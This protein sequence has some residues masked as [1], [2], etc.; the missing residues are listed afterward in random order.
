MVDVCDRPGL[1]ERMP[2]IEKSKSTD[3]ITNGV[4]NVDMDDDLV[5]TDDLPKPKETAK[6]EQVGATKISHFQ[7]LTL[8]KR[9][10]DKEVFTEKGL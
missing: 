7:C 3:T 4:N 10:E 6:S 5:D 2:L 1:L 9:R 8:A